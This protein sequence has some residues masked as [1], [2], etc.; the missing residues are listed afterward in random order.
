MRPP[1]SETYSAGALL[2]TRR[3]PADYL[4]EAEL[5]ACVQKL[6]ADEREVIANK[7]GRGSGVTDYE[8]CSPCGDSLSKPS[9]LRLPPLD[10]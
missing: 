5:C 2:I 4:T 3:Y 9:G 8:N 10:P 1:Y 7:P 6:G